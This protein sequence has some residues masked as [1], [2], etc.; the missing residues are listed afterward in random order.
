MAK[1]FERILENSLNSNEN[2]SEMKA[3]EFEYALEEDENAQQATA[4]ANEE[5]AVVLPDQNKEIEMDEKEIAEQESLTNPTKI[6]CENFE[7]SK[8]S[9]SKLSEEEKSSGA[10]A[11]NVVEEN[12]SS[13]VENIISPMSNI[14]LNYENL[15]KSREAI[16]DLL[17][18]RKEESNDSLVIW[19]K[20][21][22]I[23]TPFSL[24]LCEKLRLILEP[25]VA[26]RLKGDYKSGKRIN[27]RKMI[28]YIASGYK[29]DKIWLKRTKPSKRQYQVLISID[30]SK[31]MLESNAASMALESLA[32][33][34]KALNI[35]EIGQL[36]VV[37]FGES[38]NL[39]LGFED[40]WTSSTGAQIIS[41][42]DF[43]QDKTHMDLLLK[44]S[45]DYMMSS[46]KQNSSNSDV[47]QLHL[48]ISDGICQDHAA[49][50][51]MVREA[52]SQRIVIV[53]L[54]VDARKDTIVSMN[55]VTYENVNG[56][57]QLKMA[58]YLDSFP[59]E[60]YVVIRNLETLPLVL[61]DSIKQWFDMIKDYN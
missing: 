27:M 46:R 38:A 36:G 55:H 60:H 35:L 18:N 3:K 41:N 5:E 20:F 22:R 42:M 16:S 1:G 9:I 13:L 8:S 40:T 21:D 26:S 24:E 17:R 2:A 61:S 29:K 25:T 34:S 7:K 45:L 4:H 47:W 56:K 59:F 50:L 6:E 58:K 31:S 43:S 54:I 32:L 49:L 15:I 14:D 33:I 48:I 23:V 53:F 10:K 12:S 19:E 28:P 30:D 51:K 39:L 44:S 52:I 37:S 57:M 11:S